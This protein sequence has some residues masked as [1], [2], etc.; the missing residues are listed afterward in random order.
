LHEIGITVA[1]S[2]YHKHSAYILR[3]ADMPGF[4]RMEQERLALLVLAH[5][6][7]LRKVEEVVVADND[8]PAVVALRLAAL[9]SRSR[10][11]AALP[12][13]SL[14]HRNGT[15]I[16]GV[17]RTAA[18]NPLTETA[19]QEELAWR[20]SGRVLEIRYSAPLCRVLT[21]ASS[22]TVNSSLPMPAHNTSSI[23]LHRVFSTLM[24]A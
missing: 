24:R 23:R 4:S 6:G 19:L 15:F 22:E 14:K 2:G 10:R 7:Q 21:A 11:E 18:D 17:P 12:E 5:R 8:W 16:L 13:F 1:Y 9:F 3:N 20:G